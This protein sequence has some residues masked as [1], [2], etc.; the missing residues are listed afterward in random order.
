MTTRFVS[1]LCSFSSSNLPRVY[2][3]IF[4]CSRTQQ[5]SALHLRGGHEAAA[6]LLLCTFTAVRHAVLHHALLPLRLPTL[7]RDLPHRLLLHVHSLQQGQ[8]AVNLTSSCFTPRV[9]AVS[10][11]CVDCERKAADVCVSDL[12]YLYLFMGLSDVGPAV[13]TPLCVDLHRPLADHLGISLPRLRS[14]LCSAAY[15][16]MCLQ[17]CFHL[18]LLYRK[19]KA[20]KQGYLME[21]F[22]IWFYLSFFSSFTQCV[23]DE[24]YFH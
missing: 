23:V 5:P 15:P 18:W 24:V 14:T 7:L 21:E 6:F 17:K 8:R 11:V 12:T 10:N 4:F 2:L 20:E 16:L 22:F 1:C 13:Q 19:V 3:F 9:K